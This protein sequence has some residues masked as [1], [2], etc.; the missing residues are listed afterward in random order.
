MNPELLKALK[1]LEMSAGKPKQTDGDEAGED[2]ATSVS[3][4]EN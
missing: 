1:A 2:E 4:A 3:N